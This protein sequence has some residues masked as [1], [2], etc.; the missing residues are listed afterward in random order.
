[1]LATLAAAIGHET[2]LEPASR[3][4]NP[5]LAE[6]PLELTG[7]APQQVQG[8][9]AL[10]E[11]RHRHPSLVG[12]VDRDLEAAELLRAELDGELADIAAHPDKLSED[13]REALLD[14]ARL[15]IAKLDR[16]TS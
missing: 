6:Q 13:Q 3:E 8:L 16:E 15:A 14:C 7:L 9:G 2:Q 5:L 10:G 11:D 4:R 1:M 12:E